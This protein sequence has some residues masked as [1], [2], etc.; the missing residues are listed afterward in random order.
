M[1]ILKM[2]NAHSYLGVGASGRRAHYLHNILL[3][4]N[5][6]PM[7]SSKLHKIISPNLCNLP[8]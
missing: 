2:E 3:Y 1:T 8:C 7:S 5:F 6:S 4:Q